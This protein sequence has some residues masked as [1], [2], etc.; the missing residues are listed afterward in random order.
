MKPA[1]F[2]LL[3]VDDVQEN[4]DLLSRRLEKQGFRLLTAE[5]GERA[6]ALVAS[7][8]VDLVLL[9][10]MMPGMNGLQVLETLRRTYSATDLPIVMV[11]AKAESENVVEALDLGANDYV[12]KPIDF[13][14]VLS[15]VNAQL[16]TKQAARETRG[17]APAEVGPGAVLVGKYRLD[18]KIGSGS[19]GSVYRGHHLG[20]DHPVAVKVLQA[21]PE[22]AGD[23]YSRFQREGITAC[24]VKHPHAVAV[25]DF[26]LTPSG[27]AFLVMELLEGLSL[28]QALRTAGTLPPRRCAQILGPV[29]EALAAAHAAGIVHR[30]VKPGNIFLHR[31]SRGEVPKVLDFGIAKLLGETAVGQQATVEGWI[32]GTPD[33]M[34]PERLRGLPAEGRSDVYAVGVTLFQMLTGRLPFITAN[35]DP[36]ALAMM[37]LNEAPPRVRDLAPG[38]PQAFDDLVARCLGKD[39]D[40]RPE[41]SEM[42]ALLAAAADAPRPVLAGDDTAAGPP[43]AS[44]ASS[45]PTAASQAGQTLASPMPRD[46]APPAAAADTVVEPASPAP[47]GASAGPPARLGSGAWMRQLLGRAR[48]RLRR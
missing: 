40:L 44:A 19:F 43:A 35:S 4:R 21:P 32:L 1:D 17:P 42:V 7:E 31:G 45:S 8:P 33:Y 24:R 29:C 26:G 10:I 22:G 6:L 16:R 11:T 47:A 3:V 15:R 18:T 36:M 30:D 5:G 46:E 9:D 23:A 2:T 37:H 28:D 13:P 25:L 41:A 34:A 48:H 12:T 20:L 14:V 38:V 27:V 39:P